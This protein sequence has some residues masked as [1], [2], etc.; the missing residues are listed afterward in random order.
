MIGKEG[1]RGQV[2]IFIIIGI[3]IVILLILL[4]LYWPQIFSKLSNETKNP[5]G[6][7]QKCIE[8][9]L[10]DN[11]EI[12]LLHGGDFVSSEKTGYLYR[13]SND[14]D[15]VYV[16]YLCYTNSNRYVPCI[17]Q[18]P[19]LKSH[20]EAEILDSIN[21]GMNNC[22]NSLVESYEDDGYIV[23]LKEGNPKTDIVEEFIRINFNRTLTLTK[24]EET[25]VYRRFQIEL[26]S[27]LY[28][29]LEIA[30]NI[31]SW[32]MVAGDSL[33]EAYMYNNPFLIVE[34]HIKSDD[35]KIYVITDLN[36]EESFRFAT[37]SYPINI[38]LTEYF[39]I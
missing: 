10:E 36:T 5:S 7:I 39:E 38:D 22:F 33:P 11:I 35:T 34:K 27:N 13:H 1:K 28:E 31:V 19:F 12:I 9:E 24:G 8:D 21:D 20:I 4:Y 2:T 17:N 29:I 30:D 3:L 26:D 15:P 32:E 37:R 14:E 25:D 23:D 6:F 16:K 18:E